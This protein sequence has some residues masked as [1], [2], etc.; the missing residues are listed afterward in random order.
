[1]GRRDTIGSGSLKQGDAQPTDVDAD[2]TA[3][4][5]LHGVHLQHCVSDTAPP[6][7]SCNHLSF[8]FVD[9]SI[10]QTAEFPPKFSGPERLSQ[11]EH[12]VETESTD[13][14]SK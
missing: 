4:R 9:T 2:A 13:V 7:L 8:I 5:L 3:S 6:R 11:P 14:K 1:V 10:H 12:R